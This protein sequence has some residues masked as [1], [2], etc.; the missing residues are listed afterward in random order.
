[1]EKYNS[2]GGPLHDPN[3]IAYL[4]KPEL[5]KGRHINVQVET[6]SELTMG[7]TVADWWRVSGR[8]ANAVWIKD[9]DRDGFFDLLLERIARLP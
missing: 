4:L 5:Y 6:A 9:V 7:A 1:V 8:E 3:V 2:E